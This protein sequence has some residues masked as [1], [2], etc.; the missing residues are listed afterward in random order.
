M[1]CKTE[2]L[3][4]NGLQQTVFD[5][6][7]FHKEHSM[8]SCKLTVTTIVL[9]ISL[10]AA[11]KAIQAQT[12]PYFAVGKNAKY[13]SQASDNPGDYSGFGI[14]FPLGIHF[15]QGNVETFD[16]DNPLVLTWESTQPQFTFGFLG[17]IFFD[18][19]G[20]VELMT[21]DGVNF[22]AVWNGEF[23]V[24]GGTGLFRFV[25]PAEEPLQVVAVNNPFQLTDPEWTFDWRLTGS[26]RLF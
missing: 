26:I 18:A 6:E 3:N 14:G 17:A 10:F 12:I 19:S 4:L 23:E 1:D 8:K 15:F 13:S 16:T 22:T 9:L 20:S 2:T 5:F 24:V 11:D 25:K 21:K 7:N